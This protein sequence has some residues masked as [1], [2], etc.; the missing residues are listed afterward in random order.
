MHNTHLNRHPDIERT[1]KHT[2][3]LCK[4]AGVGGENA[5]NVG[6]PQPPLAWLDGTDWSIQTGEGKR[7]SRRWSE[8]GGGRCSRE[9]DVGSPTEYMSAQYV[10]N[11]MQND[12]ITFLWYRLSDC[13]MADSLT[14][15]KVKV[16]V[17]ADMMSRCCVR[18]ACVRSIV[19]HMAC[20]DIGF[21]CP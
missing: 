10:Q 7:N 8:H 13:P 20:V 6:C 3:L 4:P 9:G 18:V 17:L 19:L 14:W 11:Q 21:Y 12:I 5:L 2:Y 1:L 16:R 15:L